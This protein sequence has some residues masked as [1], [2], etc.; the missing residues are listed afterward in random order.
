MSGVQYIL[1]GMGLFGF[2]P[3]AII[4]WKRRI[5][6]RILNTGIRVDA[7]VYAIHYPGKSAAEIVA[8]RFLTAD[9][10]ACRICH[11]CRLEIK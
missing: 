3:L 9:G 11:F 7:E 6:N 8:Y 5:V 4:L 1:V 10:K 2:L